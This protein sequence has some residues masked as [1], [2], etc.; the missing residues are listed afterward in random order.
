MEQNLEH[1]QEYFYLH[2]K[3]VY[4]TQSLLASLGVKQ[5][6][7]IYK[8]SSNDFV[9]WPFSAAEFFEAVSEAPLDPKEAEE[10]LEGQ[11][12]VLVEKINAEIKGYKDSGQTIA[13]QDRIKELRTQK[14]EI[15]ANAALKSDGAKISLVYKTF[16]QINDSVTVE[17]KLPQFKD[18][19]W[20]YRDQMPYFTAGLE[21]FAQA[22]QNG[23]PT[24]ITGGPCFF[25]EHEVDMIF[26]LKDGS[27]KVY[28]F[29]TRRRNSGDKVSLEAEFTKQYADQVADVSFKS[30]KSLFYT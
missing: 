14:K 30:H 9:R 10:K 29:T 19:K 15:M 13:N 17:K 22:I 5:E 20:P 12:K 3:D 1:N 18:V 21:D 4:S 8:E 2:G 11:D 27:Q 7:T 23:E 25:G 26:T 6:N 16:V 24:A 28:D